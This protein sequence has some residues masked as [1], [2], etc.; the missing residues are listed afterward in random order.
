M[1]EHGT[2]LEADGIVSV[3]LKERS[4]GWG[5]HVI[6]FLAAGTAVAATGEP[7]A[8]APPSAV[9]PLGR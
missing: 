7:P 6:E 5:S 4:Y 1:R 2:R 8:D 9:V 3:E